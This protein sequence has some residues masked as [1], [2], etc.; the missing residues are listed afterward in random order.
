MLTKVKKLWAIAA[1]AGCCA[2]LLCENPVREE[3]LKW[4]SAVDIPINTSFQL[5][6]ISGA[7]FIDFG[8]NTISLPDDGLLGFILRLDS[9]EAGYHM[10]ITNYS[11]V[12]ITL[13][14]LIF[15]TYDNEAA[16]WGID[17]FYYNLTAVNILTAASRGRINLLGADGLRVRR[18]SD[19]TGSMDNRLNYYLGSLVKNPGRNLSWRWLAQFDGSGNENQTET[20]FFD[21]RSKISISGINSFDSLFNF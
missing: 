10:G 14:G 16:N 3:T 12:D 6:S 7:G 2:F 11:D 4:R 17:D 21:I 15:S 5:G 13:Y 20:N 9:L 1:I 19:T 8:T 18:G